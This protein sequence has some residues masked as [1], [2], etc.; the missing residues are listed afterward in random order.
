MSRPLKD[1]V[2]Y[3]PF[4]VGLFRDKKMKLIRSE[5]GMKGAY[6]AL[7]VL[8]CVYESDGYFKN[9]DDDDCLLM[10]VDIGCGCTPEKISE[11]VQGCVRRS[12][13][14]K[15]VFDLFHVLTSTG[16]QRR[17]L[18]IVGKNRDEIRIA[19]EYW[20]LNESVTKDVPASVC[21]KLSF[22][23]VSSV[24]NPVKSAE[25]PLKSTDN[26]Q[27]K[28]KERKE[29]ESIEVQRIADM[30]NQTCVSFQKC[31]GLSETRKKTIRARISAGHTLESFGRLF[32]LAQ[33]SAFLKGSNER[34]W[35]AT[36]DWLIQDGNMQK[37]LDGNYNDQKPGQPTASYDMDKIK[38][39][40]QHAT[41][42]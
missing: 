40:M 26:P 41:I 20:L 32:E 7:E 9:W 16:I 4:D 22:F 3:W 8:N 36:F 25:N 18:R 2:D 28:G 11:V 14:D 17:Y 34:K 35:K 33:A 39:M 5:F 38:W 15:R 24:E 1:G 37:V 29:K 13:F 30:Y 19:R 12:L 6:I 42:E 23:S 21:N 10:S 31:T 27:R